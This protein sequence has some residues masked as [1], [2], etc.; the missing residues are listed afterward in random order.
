[1]PKDQDKS[2]S[3]YPYGVVLFL[4]WVFCERYCFFCY[5]TITTLYF[6]EELYLSR[7]TS[8]S[9][10][11]AFLTI[12]YFVP[13][14]GGILADAWLGS[15]WTIIHISMIYA[16]GNILSCLSAFPL[17][18]NSRKALSFA[19]LLLA[20]IGTGGTKPCNPVFGGDQFE[21]DQVTQRHHFFSVFYAVTNAAAITSTFLTPQLR[22]DFECFAEDTCYALA[23]GF[24]AVIFIMS[25]TVFSV[26]KPFYKTPPAEGSAFV[27]VFKCIARALVRKTRSKGETKEHWLD[28]ANDK[29][30]KELIHDIKSF[31]RVF[32]MFIPLPIFWALF[33]QQGSTWL[34][35][36]A[37]MDG[38]VMGFRIKPDHMQ[39]VNPV[40]I[41]VMMPLFEYVIYPALS[42]LRLCRRPLQKMVAGGLLTAIAFIMSGFIQ[43]QIEANLPDKMPPGIAEVSILN[44]SPCL[45]DIQ[46]DRKYDLKPFKERVI[47]VPMGTKKRWEI[48]PSHCFVTKGSYAH[49]NFNVQFMKMLVTISND[50]LYVKVSGKK[51]TNTVPP[52]MRIFFSTDY[53]F[54]DNE[55]DSFLVEGTSKSYY[56]TPLALSHPV[57]V[58]TT[59]FLII[60]PGEYR[61]YLPYNGTLHQNEPIGRATFKRGGGY[62]V[63]IFQ[64][65]QQNISKLSLFSIIPPYSVPLLYQLPQIFVVSAGEIMFVVTGL[66]FAYSQA[67]YSLKSV[68]Q[69]IWLIAHAIG[70]LLVISIENFFA[71]EKQSNQFFMYAALLTSS[72]LVFAILGHF[73][74]YVDDR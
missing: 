14:L 38:E 6:T 67:P 7:T 63:G 46:G 17:S 12:S 1:M 11:H 39:L 26:C 33:A 74:R 15:F 34:L 27:S 66:E 35:Q 51:R 31:I 18:L 13:L 37:S 32:R 24:S 54:N 71:F 8:A 43:L 28:Y 72:M 55:T 48:T 10:F 19:G 16:I 44:N 56:A 70:N 41:V 62:I 57:S 21:D 68:V 29:Y 53:V 47:R 30:D 64:D 42:E 60:H 3:R 69:S 20:G 59:Q 50:A 25:L 5:Q 58:G 49:F 22:G 65:S 4:F 9:I 36:A 73:Y 52:A 2:K 40:L 61:I 45:L 23:F